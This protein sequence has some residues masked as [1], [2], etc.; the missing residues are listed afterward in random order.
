M[1]MY[2]LRVDDMLDLMRFAGQFFRGSA[3]QPPSCCLSRAEPP[4]W[5]EPRTS[6]RTSGCHQAG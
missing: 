4:G 6:V 1:K 3:E 2:R 5:S